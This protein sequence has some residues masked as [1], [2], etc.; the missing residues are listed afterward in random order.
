[1][2]S[3][4]GPRDPSPVRQRALRRRAAPC[5]LAGLALALAGCAGAQKP[6]G[7]EFVWPLPPDKPRVKHVRSFSGQNDF[8]TSGWARFRRALTGSDRG[9]SLLNPVAVALS[10]DEQRLYVSC[11]GK[12]YVLVFDREAGSVRQFP[13]QEGYEPKSPY[14][15]ATDSDGALFVSDS[16]GGAVRVYARD[17]KFLR[18]IGRGLVERP[19]GIAIDRRRRLVYV[20]DGGNRNSTRHLVEAFAPDG[21]HVRTFGTSGSGPAQFLFPTNV[22]VAPDGNVYVAD[23]LNSRIQV[24]DPEGTLVTMFGFLGDVPG[25]F[26]KVKGLAFDA[27][28]NLHVVDG[29]NIYVQIF[30]SKHQTLMA[31]GGFGGDPALMQLPNGI[32]IDSRNMIFVADFA[33]N[34]VKQYELIDTTAEDSLAPAG[35]G[36]SPPAKGGAAG[37][38]PPAAA[39]QPRGPAAPAQ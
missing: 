16:G 26:G 31:Y 13:F 4:L 30:N 19:V 22:A 10:P 37:T 39:V 6:K 3:S 29:Q 1:M 20:V 11:P 24:F 8:A 5:V 35:D 21:R 23:T 36:D 32:A 18:Q 34:Q 38:A 7:S 28:G 17:G 14:G 15:L 12:G 33:A 27:F 9:L 25:A 2:V